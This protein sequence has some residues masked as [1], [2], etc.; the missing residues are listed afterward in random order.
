[1]PAN[2]PGKPAIPIGVNGTVLRNSGLFPENFIVNNPQ[3]SNVTYNTNPGNSIYH[4]LQTSVTVR[5]TSGISWQGTYSWQKGIA[6]GSSN[7][8]NVTDRAL[9]RGVQSSNRKHDFRTNGTFE[10]PFGPNK[11]VLGNSSGVLA[12]AIERWQLSAILNLTSGAP[13]SIVSTN[14]YIGASTVV[15]AR[16]W[17]ARS[18][19]SNMDRLT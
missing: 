14:T 13:L 2:N 17:W 11:W 5:P 1:M 12:R 10:L 7:F 16:T 8:L 15:D 6:S 9:D 18:S 19:F 3:F 4:S